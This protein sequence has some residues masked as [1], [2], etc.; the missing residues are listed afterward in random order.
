MQSW[1]NNT[2]ISGGVHPKTYLPVYSV[3]AANNPHKHIGLVYTVLVDGVRMY[4]AYHN[5]Y[6][7]GLPLRETIQEAANDCW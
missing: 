5:G 4:E 3:Y 1:K 2:Y 7:A 6:P